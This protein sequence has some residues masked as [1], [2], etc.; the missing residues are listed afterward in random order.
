MITTQP[1][2]FREV[3]AEPRFRAVFLARTVWMAA[4]TVQ[5]ATLSVMVYRDTGSSLLG[6]LA[7]GAGFLPQ[8]LGGIFLGAVADRVRP[9]R[10]I[11]GGYLLEAVIAATLA[12]VHPPVG[13]ALALVAAVGVAAPLCNG[14]TGR[15]IADTL[16]GDAYV[17]GRAAV[18]M[19]SSGAQL[20]GLAAGGLVV[21]ALGPQRAFL[22]ACAG[23]L[24]AALVFRLRPARA[25]SP[26]PPSRPIRDGWAGASRLIA[27]RAV[28]RLLLAQWLP[29]AFST[30]SE[31]LLVPY[32][33]TRGW[34]PGAAGVLLAAMPLGML[35]GDAVMSRLVRPAVRERTVPL[36]IALLGAPLPVLVARPPLPVALVLLA[37]SGSG[38]AYLVGLQ[39]PFLDAV[40]PDARG[41]AFTLL[42]T[43]MMTLQGIG[44]LVMG[45]GAE[46]LGPAP[47]IALA[48]AAIVLI[49]LMLRAR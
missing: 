46:A 9:H 7:F 49:G 18:S 1:A 4:S 26:A 42:S 47:A 2:T 30:G 23:H 22:A 21:G 12:L 20:V 13:W 11:L 8:A 19:S 39:R 44:P 15:L 10:L 25:A 37:I 41:Q 16:T 31:A 29:P 40:P 43:G 38:L 14:A 17:L 6:A 45:L 24:L 27:D 36:L 35:I 33:S 48:G 3:F 5:I 34:P 28:R 32:A